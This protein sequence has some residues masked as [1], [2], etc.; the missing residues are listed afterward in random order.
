MIA[1]PTIKLVHLHGAGTSCVLC[2]ADAHPPRI[3]YWGEEL[4]HLGP[5]TLWAMVLGATHAQSGNAPNVP[6]EGGIIPLAATG[7]MGRPGLV[8]HQDGGTGWEPWFH[9]T[10]VVVDA[11]DVVVEE[12]VVSA[13]QGTVQY[14]LEDT[15][16]GLEIGLVVELLSSGLLRFHADI[17]N[18]ADRDYE[19]SEL[20]VVVPVPLCATEFLDF[21]G[22]WGRE[23]EPQR[24]DVTVGCHLREGRHGRTGFDAPMMMF[25]GTPRF[26]FSQGQL[27]GIHVATSGNHR[28]WLERTPDGH[29]V[30]G[31]GE[32]LMPGE[33]VLKTGMTYQGP[34]VYLDQAHG[35]DAAAHRV[36]EWLR[37]LPGH[38]DVNRPVT[39]NVWEA[40]Y[41]N[42][43]LPTLIA[44][45]DKAASVG[46]ERYVIDD[47]W[48]PGRRDD[49][50]G[51]GDWRV[52][53]ETWPDGFHP[54]VDHVRGLGMQFG[55]W[56]EPEMI[57]VNSDLARS[58]PD[59]IMA[60]RNELPVEWRRQQVL[61]L[62]I[63]EAWSHI[64]NAL[65]SLVSEYSIDYFKWDHNRD[66]I[67]AGDQRN[68]GVPAIHE[69]TLACYRLMDAL[70]ARHPGLDIESCSSGG[71][72]VDLEMARH[73]QRF[74]L[75]DCIDPHERQDIMRWTS[76]LIPP[77][78]MG[79][80]IASQ[81][82]H[83]TGRISTVS[84]RATT[85]LWGH[86]GIEWNLL[87]AS[88]AEI[89][90]LRDWINFYKEQRETLLS[91]RLVRADIGDASLRLHGIVSYSRD[92][93]LYELVSMWRSPI[94]P[95]G[96]ITLPGL[97]DARTYR[98]RPRLVAGG[99][100][101]LIAPPWFGQDEEGVVMEG[102]VLRLCGLQVP[103]LFPDQ[104][105]VLEARE[106]STTTGDERTTSS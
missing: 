26:G 69:Q 67:S 74:W 44:L 15:E 3:I 84:F 8:G 10:S 49:T 55:L 86:L 43:D 93:A 33:V 32:L 103:L 28:S 82:S 53:P 57:N 50:A 41:F 96:M 29:Q 71:A 79:T 38:P 51:L 81:Q 94:S 87:A 56:V 22:R 80:H 59:W 62:T 24:S 54:L 97:D 100:L 25:C 101:G 89:D 48:F 75:S 70:R 37:S 58:H 88:E 106:V 102:R 95:S 17:T 31:G 99:P 83:T 64:F 92:H 19:L 13:G 9:T 20:S 47:G 40:V 45:A 72:R 90:E 105:L 2:T 18:T 104:A 63:P 42:H 66:L 34:W 68:G 98:V 36:H 52:D 21:A 27:W 11:E 78:M 16:I 46:A 6:I 7:W 35:L 30:L 1:D 85:A 39:F 12:G 14:A 91:G 77:E 5:Q 60:A 76:Q 65:D 23:R 61:N 73:A 4:G